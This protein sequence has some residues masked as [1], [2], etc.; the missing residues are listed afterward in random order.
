MA[1]LLAGNIAVPAGVWF[2][3]IT[4]LKSRIV[5]IIPCFNDIMSRPLSEAITIAFCDGTP[6]PIAF[7]ATIGQKD[8]LPRS[9]VAVVISIR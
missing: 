7:F 3:T 8:I 9:M 1:A 4:V 2:A 5:T 6:V